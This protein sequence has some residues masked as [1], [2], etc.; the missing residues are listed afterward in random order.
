[1]SIFQRSRKE[2]SK[3]SKGLVFGLPTRCPACGKPG[4]LDRIDLVDRVMFQ[5]CPWCSTNWQVSEAEIAAQQPV[6]AER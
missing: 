4:Y 1:M 5:H 3:G 6:P 2:A